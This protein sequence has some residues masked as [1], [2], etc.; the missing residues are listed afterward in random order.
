MIIEA[1]TIQNVLDMIKEK[2]PNKRCS[3]GRFPF[4]CKRHSWATSQMYS[5]MSNG[6]IILASATFNG[7]KEKLV[8]L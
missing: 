2:F 4:S 5:V 8:N 3:L 7:L 1:M 6:K